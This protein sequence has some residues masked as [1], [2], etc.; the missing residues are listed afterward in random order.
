M[1]GWTLF[2]TFEDALDC[3]REMVQDDIAD[4]VS[5]YFA[6]GHHKQPWAVGNPYKRPQSAEDD[7]IF[8]VAK[9]NTDNFKLDTLPLMQSE[10]SECL[11][12]L[13]G[14]ELKNLYECHFGKCE[15]Q[16]ISEKQSTKLDKVAEGVSSKKPEGSDTLSSKNPEDIT[17]TESRYMSKESRDILKHVLQA[18]E[19]LNTRMIAIEKKVHGQ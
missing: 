14:P 19:N 4:N 5:V 13:I 11:E 3:A 17:K 16:P 10:I 18:L 6:Q 7:F 15:D 8:L 12:Y 2:D 9:V 1:N